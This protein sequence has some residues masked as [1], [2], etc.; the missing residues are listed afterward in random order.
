MSTRQL[1]HEWVAELAEVLGVPP[2]SITDNGFVSLQCEKDLL[3]HIGAFD[4]NDVLHFFCT[5]RSAPTD[6]QAMRQAMRMALQLNVDLAGKI[7]GAIGLSPDEMEFV[8]S[9]HFPVAGLDGEMFAQRLIV[10]MNTCLLTK[11]QFDHA[12]P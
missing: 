8:L 11:E 3:V 6:E 2:P 7:Q 9:A 5:L 1:L 4:A 12:C 10:F